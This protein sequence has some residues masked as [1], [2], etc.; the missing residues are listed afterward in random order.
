MHNAR[1][2]HTISRVRLVILATALIAAVGALDVV[3]VAAQRAAVAG[4]PAAI[5]AALAADAGTLSDKFSGLATAMAGKYDWRPGKGVRS[6]GEVFNLILTENRVLSAALDAPVAEAGQTP[7]ITD[8][9]MMAEML[10][11][12]YAALQKVIG[13]LSNADLAQPAQL[14]GRS[15][16]RQGI[17]LMVLM[18]QHEHLGQSIAY[19][20]SNGVVP[21]WSK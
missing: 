7:P 8:P 14:F 20:R 9:V 19:A 11:Q 6:V 2:A 3:P 5:Q 13:G 15:S 17:V 1:M 16:N 12:S 4:P 21:P 18:D 10:K